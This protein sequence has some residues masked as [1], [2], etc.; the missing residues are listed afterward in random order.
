MTIK[1]E[2]T[3][4]PSGNTWGTKIVTTELFPV[5]VQRPL[6][7]DADEELVKLPVV[8]EV[9]FSNSSV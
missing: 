6:E 8:V 3:T 4:E 5:A 7:Q 2:C 9:R 1:E